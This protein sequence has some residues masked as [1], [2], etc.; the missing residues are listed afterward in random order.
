MLKNAVEYY[1]KLLENSELAERSRLQL[2]SKLEEAR[3]IFGGRLLSPYLRPHFV[4][5]SDWR[6]VAATCEIIF[7]ALQKIKDAAVKSDE[8]LDELGVTGIERN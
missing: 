3:L 4:T 2:D 1:D 6:R 5:A 7:S 8:L